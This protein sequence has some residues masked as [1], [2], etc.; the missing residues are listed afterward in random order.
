MNNKQ[1][2]K[3]LLLLVL[4]MPAATYASSTAEFYYGIF[5][6]AYFW[7]FI[8][9]ALLLALSYYSVK[10]AFD[11]IQLAMR[12]DLAK[13][14]ADEMETADAD[15]DAEE[16][17]DALSRWYKW[18][19]GL[20]PMAKEKDLQLDHE[21]DGITELDN[22]LPPWWLYGF[23]VTIG[24]A[25]VYMVYFHIMDGPSSSEEYRAEMERA[26]TDVAAYFERIGGM[27]DETNVTMVEEDHRLAN[28]RDIFKTNCAVCHALDGGGGVG[29]N[30]TDEYWIHGNSI[31]SVFKVIKYGVVE[32]GMTPWRNQLSA[33]DMQDVSSYV[34]TLVGSEPANPKEPQ[35]ERM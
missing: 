14:K 17:G 2:I 34:L 9:V 22:S 24:F 19:T 16:S 4:L 29:P 11:T 31:S 12:P 15:V 20:K 3:S 10:R 27:V 7:L 23:Y 35:G 25:V 26:K 32:K 6:D 28:G 13:K 8:L 21:Y 1:P 30:L 5:N 33:S 18:F